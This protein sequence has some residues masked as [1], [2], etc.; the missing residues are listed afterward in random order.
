MARSRK[1]RDEED[2]EEDEIVVA[3]PETAGDAA[4][5]E[6]A[7]AAAPLKPDEEEIPLEFS[8]LAL[9][10]PAQA[11]EVRERY[12]GVEITESGPGTATPEERLLQSIF[13]HDAG[14]TNI[15]Q[16]LREARTSP[17]KKSARQIV[18][19]S[20]PEMQVVG[21]ARHLADAAPASP[22]D[23]VS[24]ELSALRK[25]YFGA[26]AG[27]SIAI[28]DEDDTPESGIDTGIVLVKPKDDPSSDPAR[29]STK[30]VVVADGRIIG[31]Q[32]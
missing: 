3:P 15:V 30:A 31:R 23:A 13:G 28:S 5:I 32:G 26:D 10:D 29:P 20:L 8:E 22:P 12:F 7:A 21:P 9:S 14:K 19:E 1:R 18:Q 16:N 11:N 17:M 6:I 2:R 24:P 27:D 25:K 4:T